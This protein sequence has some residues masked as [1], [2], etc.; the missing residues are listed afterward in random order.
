TRRGVDPAAKGGADELE[1]G[2]V[3]PVA[4]PSPRFVVLK[5]SV[6]DCSLPGINQGPAV[7]GGDETIAAGACLVGTPDA[8]ITP[9]HTSRKEKDAGVGMWFG[10]RRG[11]GLKCCGCPCCWNP[12]WPGCR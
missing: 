10:C 4:A 9:E 5:A 8:R 3:T 2:P 6:D 7:S 1:T 12:R 11:L